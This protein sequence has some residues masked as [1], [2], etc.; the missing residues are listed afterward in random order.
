[1]LAWTAQ[2]AAGRQQLL[3]RVAY[4]AM[5]LVVALWALAAWHAARGTPLRQRLARNAAPLAAAL[6]ATIACFVAVPPRQRMQFDETSLLATAQ[7][8]HEHRAAMM[9][10][11]ALP[12]PTGAAL[13]EWNLDKRPALFPFL[14][15][16]AHD[17]S[18][19]RAANAFVVN[20]LLV[21]AVLAGIAAF[22]RSRAGVLAAVATPPLLLAVPALVGAATSA[23][24]ELL[25]LAL[26]AATVLAAIRFTAAPSAPAAAWLAA[27]ALACAHARYESLPLALLVVALAAARARRWPLDRVGAA[28]LLAAP[29]LLAPLV[30]L[31][32]HARAG[33]FY[34]EAGTQPL[35][36]LGHLA[37]LRWPRGSGAGAAVSR[38]CWCSRRPRPRR[39]CPCRG[40]TA[41]CAS[42]PRCGCSCRSR[43]SPRWGRCCWWSS[44]TVAGAPPPCSQRRSRSRRARST[45]RERRPRCRRSTPPSRSKRSR[46]RCA[47]STPTRGARCWSAR[48]RSS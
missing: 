38:S 8:M 43:C 25:A 47:G 39:W 36:E 3:G 6:L 19:Y 12:A 45:R 26:L 48:S 17:V 28:V 37:D 24:F 22:V 44:S 21:L 33:H 16:V 10:T 34:P 31:A 15:S 2:D 29:S 46:P 14:V 5:P 9:G 30:L 41:T 40:S 20:G 18:G 32:L 7:G 42:R 1:V 11:V 4:A 23:G 27:N 13:V 35:F